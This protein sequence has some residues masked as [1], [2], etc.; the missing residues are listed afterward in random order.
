[1]RASTV[2]GALT[3]VVGWATSTHATSGQAI[4]RGDHQ[5]DILDGGAAQNEFSSSMLNCHVY[6]ITAHVLLSQS[7]YY[8]KTSS[9]PY[10]PLQ[11]IRP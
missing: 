1:M 10:L 3:V 2:L 8:P 6:E 11:N 4:F 9:L 5:G 7:R